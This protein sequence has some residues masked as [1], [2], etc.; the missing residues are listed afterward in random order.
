MKP[1]RN[2]YAVPAKLR[3]G[4]GSHKG[5]A[6]YPTKEEQ[7]LEQTE[8]IMCGEITDRYIVIY[9]ESLPMCIPCQN[10]YDINDVSIEEEYK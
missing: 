8:C 1:M 6:K 4:G 9:R 5:M 7:M 3:S 10:A 2:A